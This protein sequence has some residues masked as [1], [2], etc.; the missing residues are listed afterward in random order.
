MADKYIMD[1]HKLHWHLDRVNDW[2]NGKR[3]TPLHIDVGLSKGCNIRCQYCFGVVQGNFYR[4]G[5]EL[6]FPRAPLLSYMR[7]A[8]EAGVRS[9]ALIGEA[10]PLLNPAVYEAIVEGKKAG[11]DM[12]LGTNGILYDTGQEGDRSAGVFELDQV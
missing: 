12:S 1:G 8:G 6:Y 3:V 9:I 5:S 11:V 10:E 7:E 2:L 4:K